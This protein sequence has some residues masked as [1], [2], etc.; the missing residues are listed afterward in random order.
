[1]QAFT[2][3]HAFAS[4][5]SKAPSGVDQ[6]TKPAESIF[7]CHMGCDAS[8]PAMSQAEVSAVCHDVCAV[9]HVC[10]DEQA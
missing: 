7:A 10:T 3:C 5:Q 2:F 9:H 6:E 1:M 4:R 8:L